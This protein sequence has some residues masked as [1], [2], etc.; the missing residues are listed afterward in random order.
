M[1]HSE[2]ICQYYEL[3][4][5]YREKMARYF[6]II[7][8]KKRISYTTLVDQ[9]WRKIISVLQPVSRNKSGQY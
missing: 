3:A 9:H 7:Y 2:N 8:F 4:L 5:I 1:T 6:D